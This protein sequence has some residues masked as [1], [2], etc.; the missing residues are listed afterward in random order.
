MKELIR[1]GQHTLFAWQAV[2]WV[3]LKADSK[4]GLRVVQ[5]VDRKAGKLAG[6]KD[7]KL[8]D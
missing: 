4:V 7:R 2:M 5:L 1:E 6:T 8:V 3:V